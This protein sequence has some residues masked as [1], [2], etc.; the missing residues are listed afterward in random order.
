[1]PG[2]HR[3]PAERDRRV[4]R[5]QIGHIKDRRGFR[6]MMVGHGLA[7]MTPLVHNGDR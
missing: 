1:M 2:R 4:P 6:L 3:E 5:W 7:M